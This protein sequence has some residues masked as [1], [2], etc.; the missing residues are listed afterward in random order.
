M[1]R[2][3][4]LSDCAHGT[5]IRGSGY[6]PRSGGRRGL[7][8]ASGM[9]LAPRCRGCHRHPRPAGANGR[10]HVEPPPQGTDR[11]GRAAW[12]VDRRGRLSQRTATRRTRR[13]SPD[14][15]RHVGAGDPRRNLR[16]DAQ[17]CPGTWLR[18]RA[19]IPG[20]ALRRSCGMPQSRPQPDDPALPLPTLSRTVISCATCGR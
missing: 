13:T 3:P 15:G 7:D 18:R 8:I 16:Q 19:I 2:R 12:R 20:R 5:G 14:G 4:R 17:P 11:L 10:D 9:A 6:R 1:G